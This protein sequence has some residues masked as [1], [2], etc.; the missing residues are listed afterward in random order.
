M[1]KCSKLIYIFRFHWLR[2]CGL[3]L[4]AAK[5]QERTLRIS[6]K[7]SLAT[8]G[9]GKL[10][11]KPNVTIMPVSHVEAFGEGCV[12]FEGSN[13]VNRNCVIVSMME[14]VIGKGTTIGPGVIMYDHDHDIHD[15]QNP[16]GCVGNPIHIGE[17]VWIGAGA[18][19]LKGVTI[20]DH[21][22]IAAGSIVT[23][24]VPANTIYANQITHKQIAL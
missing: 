10:C 2:L 20:G 13:Y 22:V 23:R 16:A 8:P 11:F 19:V 9:R 17:H 14:I 1:K 5:G 21:A 3:H 7:A 12:L 6:P 24:D 4:E 18:I 15:L